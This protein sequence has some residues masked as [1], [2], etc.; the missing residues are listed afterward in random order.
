MSLLEHRPADLLM[1]IPFWAV[2]IV[3]LFFVGVFLLWC[4]HPPTPWFK[5]RI[6]VLGGVALVLMMSAWGS[7]LPAIAMADSILEAA[8]VPLLLALCVLFFNTKS[9][10]RTYGI[11]TAVVLTGIGFA[12]LDLLF[13]Q[14]SSGLRSFM[15]Y[16]I[17]V[18]GAVLMC[19]GAWK[20]LRVAPEPQA[21]QPGS[22]A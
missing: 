8:V 15:V 2:A 17:W 22:F 21:K 10:A 19:V 4:I 13:P 3:T 9:Y 20:I 11:G 5:S 1:A 14:N 7:G 18:L 6:W 16:G 12:Y